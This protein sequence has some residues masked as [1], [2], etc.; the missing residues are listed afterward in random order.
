MNESEEIHNIIGH[1]GAGIQ[2]Y[3]EVELIHKPTGT[4]KQKLQFPNVITNAALDRIG[5]GTGA[6]RSYTWA[7]VGTGTDTPTTTDTTLSAQVVRTDSAGSPSIAG[8]NFYDT[9]GIYWRRRITRVFLSGVGTGNLTEVGLFNA[10]S[11]GTMLCRQLFRDNAGNPTTIVKTADD[12]LRI[13]YEFRI[14]PQQTSNTTTLTIK[15]VS[16]TC[17]TRAYDVDSS[18]RWGAADGAETAGLVNSLGDTWQTAVGSGGIQA[19]TASAMPTLTNIQTGTAF[20]PSSAAWGSYTNGTYYLD[21]TVTLL[22]G[23]GERSIGSIIWGYASFTQPVFI[24]T[25]DPP[26]LKTAT[27]RAIFTGRFSWGRGSGSI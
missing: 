26:I 7:A 18:N 8:S 23:L 9:V 22:P 17:T 25:F 16:T 19:Y 14:Y 5:A 6:I 12:E 13:T 4:V 3:F 20:N 1:A 15:S 21:Q 11:G 2:G 27:E 24:T 10:S